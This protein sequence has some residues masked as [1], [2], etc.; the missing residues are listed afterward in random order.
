MGLL[1]KEI[2]I[3][4]N[5]RN[6]KHFE[7]L[8]YQI[9]KT[10]K[11][12][13]NKQRNNHICRRTFTVTKGSKIFV[14]Q[15]DLMSGSSEIVDVECDCCKDILK[16][17]YK[18]YKSHNH[19]G[20]YYCVP[21]SSKIF[22]GGE[23]CHLWNFELTDEERQLNRCY[24]EY[25]QF[26]KSVMARDKYTCQCCGK[27][28]D[29]VHHL[30]SYSK[31]KEL[32]TEVTNG[33]ALCKNC[34]NAFHFWH[35]TKY[36]YD[37]KGNCTKQQFEEWIGHV[38]YLKEYDGELP[39]ARKVYCIEENKTYDSATIIATEWKLTSPA[40]IYKACNKEAK[41]VKGKHL[42]WFDEYEKMSKNEVM[43]YL[44]N[45]KNNRYSS[46]I[47]ITTEEI[48]TIMADAKRKYNAKCISNV[49][50]GK[51]KNSGKLDDGT[52]LQWMYLDDYIEQNKDKIENI[53]EFIEQHTIK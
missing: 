40:Q 43:M 12:Y 23:K 3:T 46:V 15:F 7:E 35:K 53:D 49:C 52:K 51:I 19:D 27:R 50:S 31:Y 1:D 5:S 10:E 28:A 44:R 48:F 9:P 26:V 24:P 33:I 20:K 17:A 11:I 36:G 45:C 18:D 22:N 39:T 32:R 30:F 47:C 14:K 29:V 21:C 38:L 37:N 4:L 8:G 16:I 2:E 13:R 6:I 25:T 42:L 41:S 34:H